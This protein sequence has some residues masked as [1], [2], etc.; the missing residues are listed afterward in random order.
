M[1]LMGHVL[2]GI[3]GLTLLIRIRRSIIA[4]TRLL[5][6]NGASL[7]AG[8]FWAAVLFRHRRGFGHGDIPATCRVYGMRHY[9]VY[10]TRQSVNAAT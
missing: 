9:R 2:F 10:G 3:R 7:L 4:P 8:S 1:T 6:R 5:V